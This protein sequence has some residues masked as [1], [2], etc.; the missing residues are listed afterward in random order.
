MF[1]NIDWPVNDNI[2][3]QGRNGTG[4]CAGLEI[5][6]MGHRVCLSPITSRGKVGNCSI[7]VPLD[8]VEYLIRALQNMVK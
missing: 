2:T 7:D 4:K 3:F 6:L 8:K 1:I 5:G